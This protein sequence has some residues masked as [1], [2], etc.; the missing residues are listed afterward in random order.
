MVAQDVS[1]EL[2]KIQFH[3]EMA[4]SAVQRGECGADT[5]KRLWAIIYLAQYARTGAKPHDY[6]EVTSEKDTEIQ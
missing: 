3:A 6:Q 2:L 5:L 4:E 1:G